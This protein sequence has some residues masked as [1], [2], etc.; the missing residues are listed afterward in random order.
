MGSKCGATSSTGSSSTP[1]Q[2]HIKNWQLSPPIRSH[3]V[4]QA[5]TWWEDG[6]RGNISNPTPMPLPGSWSHEWCMLPFLLP[7][8][9]L[10]NYSTYTPLPR[11]KGWECGGGNIAIMGHL[12]RTSSNHYAHLH[13]KLLTNERSVFSLHHTIICCR[14]IATILLYQ[15][16]ENLPMD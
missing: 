1:S 7:I 8:E 14:Y 2:V 4:Q 3:N 15:C 6:T 5:A 13:W 12:V 10:W 9:Y 11:D 16:I